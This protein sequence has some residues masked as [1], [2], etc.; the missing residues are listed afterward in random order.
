MRRTASIVAAASLGLIYSGG[1]GAAWWISEGLPV[2]DDGGLSAAAAAYAVLGAGWFS[3]A[4]LQGMWNKSWCVF[5]VATL[6]TLDVAWTWVKD[7]NSAWE[8]LGTL[9][10]LLLAGV[11]VTS[12]IKRSGGPTKPLQPTRAAVPNGQREAAR[13]GPRG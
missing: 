11:V 6:T 7:E 9:V 3:I 2:L 4:F 8:V 10:I 5:L 12:R 13:V 1:A